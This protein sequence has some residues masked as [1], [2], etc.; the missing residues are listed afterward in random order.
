MTTEQF[1]LASEGKVFRVFD[2]SHGGMALSLIDPEDIT[3]FKVGAVVK[4]ELNL[5]RKKYAIEAEVKNFRKNELVGLEFKNLTQSVRAA[6]QKFLDPKSLGDALK[7]IP[8][9]HADQLWFHG[10]SGTDL[11]FFRKGSRVYR[12]VVYVLGSF[13]QW[14]ESSGLSTGRAVLEGMKDHPQDVVS[15]SIIQDVT[16][17]QAALLESDPAPDPGKLK[18]TEELVTSSKIPSELKSFVLKQ[19]QITSEGN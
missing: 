16:Q 15:T 10:P 3:F 4:G 2:L 19:L 17:L 5:R 8:S 11:L 1:K 12:F 14:E 18:I 6:I 7:M 13:I 9:D